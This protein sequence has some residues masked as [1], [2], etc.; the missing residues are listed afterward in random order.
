MRAALPLNRLRKL[1]PGWRARDEAL[2]RRMYEDLL[3]RPPDPEGLAHHLAALEGGASPVDLAL[4]MARTDE[5][6]A[7]TRKRQPGGGAGE[8]HD[9]IDRT[10]RELLGRE[11]DAGALRYWDAA[12]AEGAE[13]TDLA[14]AL[15]RSDEYVNRVAASTWVLEDLRALRPE[16]YADLPASDGSEAIPVYLVE[17]AEDFDWIENAIIEFGYYDKPGGWSGSIDMDKR[18]MAELIASLGPRTALEIGCYTGA[19]MRCLDDLGVRAEGVEISRTAI[20]RAFPEV[21]DRIHQGDLL[22]PDLQAGLGTYDVV[23][24]L[25]IFEH[26]NPNKL[27]RYLECIVG[28]LRPGGLVV[29]VVP[30]F[31]DDEVFETVFPTY[32]PSWDADAAAGRPF[33][34]LHVDEQGYPLHGH[35]IWAHTSWWQARFRDVGLRRLREVERALHERYDGWIEENV[36]SRRSF[37]VFALESEAA[38]AAREA[39]LAP[40]IRAE[41]SRALAADPNASPGAPAL[42]R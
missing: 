11:P 8:R 22:D 7:V 35:I 3:D 15:A 19:V 34:A 42:R 38:S 24:G 23:F 33:S 29:G 27:S 39:L 14:V 20:R 10:Y 4:A 2:V 40:A 16:R 9:L 37:Y 32:L 13:P 5:H 25:D 26:L 21:R 36:P 30:A 12:L 31:G 28:R 18:V 41:G 17:D 1:V 6:L